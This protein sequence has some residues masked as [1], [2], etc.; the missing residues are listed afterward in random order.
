MKMKMKNFEKY[1]EKVFGKLEEN[2]NDGDNLEVQCKFYRI[3]LINGDWFDTSEY[4][5]VGVYIKFTSIEN[6]NFKFPWT[7]ILWIEE[8]D[9]PLENRET[10]ETEETE[11][12]KNLRIWGK[13]VI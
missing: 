3:K 12:M 11:E 8:K 9:I 13:D 1:M 7:S 10:E 2:L 6:R 5:N 4:Q